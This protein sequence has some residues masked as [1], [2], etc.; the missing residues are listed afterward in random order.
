MQGPPTLE[1]ALAVALLLRRRTSAA[2]AEAQERCSRLELEA[3]ALRSGAAVPDPLAAVVTPP[4]GGAHSG[5]PGATQASWAANVA[6]S[7][8]RD[9]AL[10][11][12]QQHEALALWHA[13]A[14]ALPP[15]LQPTLAQA[16]R[17]LLLAELQRGGAPGRL[18]LDAAL[19]RTPVRALLDL[20]ADI[21]Q[22]HATPAGGL[23]VGAGATEGAGPTAAAAP[24]TASAASAASQSAMHPSP[25][26]QHQPVQLTPAHGALLAS[27]A[28]CIACL[29]DR[30]GEAAAHADFEALQAFCTGL[31]RLATAPLPTPD[32][33][34]A[35]A[36][37]AAG[38]Q[39]HQPASAGS[40]VAPAPTAP[41]PDAAAAPAGT[42]ELRQPT[43]GVAQ[44]VLAAL[45]QSG[46]AGI[47]LLACCAPATQGCMLELVEA[48]LGEQ[49]LPAAPGGSAA[50]AAA[51]AEEARLL[52]RFMQ[53]SGQLSAGLRLLPQWAQALS[54]FDEAFMQV[55]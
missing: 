9:V 25:A 55:S 10:Q 40:L 48:V 3:E 2:V 37:A 47:T 54:I 53:L 50:A 26:R 30:P 44:A 6:A 46:T 19:D 22:A 52:H 12:G 43:S 4:L 42:I 7:P 38:P 15:P 13:A 41:S 33:G 1:Q 45:R 29:C 31:L 18:P 11:A 51:A 21:V 39:Q 27:A 17:Y 16:Q 14:A 20:A 23:Q 5:R 28:A 32:V 49:P 34:A 35:A 36:P 24:A 8:S